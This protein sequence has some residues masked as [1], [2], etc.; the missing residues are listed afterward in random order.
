[1]T[2]RWKDIGFRLYRTGRALGIVGGAYS[3]GYQSGLAT[4]AADPRHVDAEMTKQ[5]LASAGAT[6]GPLSR[7][8]PETRYVESVGNRILAAARAHCQSK[9]VELDVIE[10]RSD[11]SPKSVYSRVSQPEPTVGGMGTYNLDE[12]RAFWAANLAKLE[13]DWQ[14]LVAA[15]PDES[16]N[17][18]VTD[19]VPRKVFVL[20]GMLT[21]IKLTPDELALCLAH[22]LSHLLLGHSAQKS[23]LELALNALQLGLLINFPE[24]TIFSDQLGDYA[25]GI[26]SKMYSREFETEADAL[27]CAIA[28]RACYDVAKGAQLFLKLQAVEGASTTVSWLRS[29]PVSEDRHQVAASFTVT[30]SAPNCRGVQ[31]DLAACALARKIGIAC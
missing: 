2:S 22:E 11:A 15:P 6:N 26:V 20:G 5:V 25:R 7:T 27:G 24:L 1:M 17:A 23:R 21:K 8:S 28:A 19:V 9:L 4:Y 29:H 3:V 31:Q 18:F 13:G 30:T 10:R 16:V 14:F 12:E